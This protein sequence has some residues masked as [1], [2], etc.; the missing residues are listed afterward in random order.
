[1][2]HRQCWEIL[3]PEYQGRA[4]WQPQ[5]E[6]LRVQVTNDSLPFQLLPRV[7]ISQRIS[8]ESTIRIKGIRQEAKPFSMVQHSL[9]LQTWILLDHSLPLLPH[10]NL[11]LSLLHLLRLPHQSL[12]RQL[13]RRPTLSKISLRRKLCMLK[14]WEE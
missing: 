13:Q 11:K 10:N 2:V 3:Q 1:M 14:I 8:I 4:L 9:L 7:C 5:E 12:P 6:S